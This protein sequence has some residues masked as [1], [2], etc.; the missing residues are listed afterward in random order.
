MNKEIQKWRDWA[1]SPLLNNSFTTAEPVLTDP[2]NPNPHFPQTLSTIPNFSSGEAPEA[3]VVPK[4]SRHIKGVPVGIPEASG[5]S[6]MPGTRMLT[7]DYN[8]M[9]REVCVKELRSVKLNMYF[10]PEWSS[11]HPEWRV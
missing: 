10:V 11:T 3:W 7:Y 5:V 6:A 9:E 8:M 1:R 2:Q 4:R